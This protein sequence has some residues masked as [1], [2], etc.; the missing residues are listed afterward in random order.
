VTC[1]YSS[2]QNFGI[3][4]TCTQS[5]RSLQ[6]PSDDPKSDSRENL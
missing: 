5:V 4:N 2:K 1:L 6:Q 3:L